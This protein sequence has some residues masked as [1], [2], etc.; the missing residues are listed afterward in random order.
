M[1]STLP[2]AQEHGQR[3]H[4][5]T[6]YAEVLDV[7]LLILLPDG[8]AGGKRVA[9]RASLIDLL[10]TLRDFAGLEGLKFRLYR[11]MLARL[12]EAV[13]LF[14]GRERARSLRS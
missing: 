10:P 8:T 7:P 14:R 9:S 2:F 12:D 4:A 3:G 6:L 11:R 1:C 5:K 13:E